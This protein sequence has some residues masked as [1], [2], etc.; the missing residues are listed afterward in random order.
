MNRKERVWAAINHQRTDYIPKGE[1]LVAR[2]LWEQSGSTGCNLGKKYNFFRELGLDLVVIPLSWQEKEAQKAEIEW[3]SRKT[4]FFVFLLLNGGFQEACFQWGWQE[5]LL[6][7]LNRP[8]ELL[9]LMKEQVGAN[10]NLAL[11]AL[12]L[13]GD[14]IIIGEDIAYQKGTLISPKALGELVFPNLAQILK[15]FQGLG[16]PVFFHSDGNLQAVLEE[17]VNLGFDGLQG[18]EPGAG[19]D[20]ALVKQKYGHRLCLMGNLDLGELGSNLE[21]NNRLAALVEK[22]MREGSPGGGYI[23]GT[24]GGLGNNL[25]LEQIKYLYKLAADFQQEDDRVLDN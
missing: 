9:K 1:I 20:L 6:A 13:G 22:T 10:I 17:I 24:A 14:G 5:T 7:T 11:E 2:E 21:K 23:F 3:W 18:I 15:V 4:D 25:A 12:E 19:M 16:M 8:Q